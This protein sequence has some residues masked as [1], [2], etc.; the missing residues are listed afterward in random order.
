MSLE[1]MVNNG[2]AKWRMDAWD[3][4]ILRLVFFLAIH[5]SS[6]GYF[7]QTKPQKMIL[8]FCKTISSIAWICAQFGSTGYFAI[9]ADYFKICGDIVASS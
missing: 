6:A 7:C 2:I 8:F 5:V 1:T 9:L 4:I 3:L